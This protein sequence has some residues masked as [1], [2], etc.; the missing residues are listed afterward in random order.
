MRERRIHAVIGIAALAAFAAC[1]GGDTGGST[2]TPADSTPAAAPPTTETGA[3][4]NLPEG[5]TAAMVAQG[6]TIFHNQG[7][8]FTC[9]GPD[10]RGTVNAPDLTDDTWINISGRNFDEIVQIVTNG[11]PQPHQYPAP[12]PAKGGST[13]TDEQVRAVAAYVYSLGQQ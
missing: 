1:G 13:I 7:L 6:D 12:M 5:V 9:H 4:T 10:A 3:P 2:E 11:V 8:C